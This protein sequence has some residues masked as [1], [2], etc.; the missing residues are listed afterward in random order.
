MQGAR[1]AHGREAEIYDWDG[2][3]AVLK[4]YRPGFGRPGAEAVALTLLEGTGV[5]PR[6]LE[7]VQVQGRDGLVMQRLDGM[8]MLAVL[9]RQPWRLAALARMLARTARRIHQLPAPSELPDL[10]G[11]LG[12][13]IGAAELPGDLRTFANRTLAGLPTGDRLCHGDL[14]PGNAIVTGDQARVID[15]PA[16]TRGTPTADV[17]RTLL[18]LRQSDPVPG[19]PSPARVVIAG[20]RSLFAGMFLRSYRTASPEPLRDLDAWTIVHAAA[21]L[22]EGLPPE[23]PRLLRIVEAGYRAAP[24]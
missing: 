8:D 16:A 14:H 6:L 5:A 11:V 24:R 1:L 3:R 4:L 15:W 13:R 12:D 2:G 10:V 17:A 9:Q 19:T 18:L 22:S 23:R 21:R 7:R 20:G